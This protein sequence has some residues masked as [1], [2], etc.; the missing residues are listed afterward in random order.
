MV[1]QTEDNHTSSWLGNLWKMATWKAGSTIYVKIIR[2]WALRTQGEESSGWSW[3]KNVSSCLM[4]T[5]RQRHCNTYF[6]YMK[7]FLLSKER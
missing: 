1:E 7:I 4:H 5:Q 6:T 3:F 2:R